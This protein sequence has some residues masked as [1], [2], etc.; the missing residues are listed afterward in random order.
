MATA[1]DSLPPGRW[2]AGDTISYMR[3]GSGQEVDFTPGSR[4]QPR[5][6]AIDHPYQ[7]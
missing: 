3:T 6:A 4:P 2:M 5:W 7:G 1:I